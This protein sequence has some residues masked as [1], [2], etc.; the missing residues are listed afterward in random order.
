MAFLGLWACLWKGRLPYHIDTRLYA[1]P[2]HCVNMEAFHRGFIPLWNPYIGCGTPHAANWQSACF[3]PPFWIF[4]FTGLQ[5]WLMWMALGHSALAFWGCY[6]WLRSQKWGSLWSA[7]GALSF[8]GSA[9]MVMCWANL[10]FIAT[11]AWIPWVFWAAHRALGKN[12]TPNWI[13]LCLFLSLQILA[14]YPFFTFYTLIFL[15][16]WFAFQKPSFKTGVSMGLTLLASALL[17]SL[18]WLPFLEFLTY[19]VHDH[20]ND[21]PYFTKPIE[22]LTLLEPGILGKGGAASYGGSFANANFNL[23]FG[24]IPLLVVGVGL[25]RIT[26]VRNK[27]WIFSILFWFLWLAGRHFILWDILPAAWLEWLEP[28]KAVGIFIFCAVTFAAAGLHGFFK[29]R[30]DHPKLNRWAWALSLLWIAD[31]LRVPFQLLH[32]MPNPYQTAGFAR[33]ISRIQSLVG[34]KRML[35]IH[36]PREMGFSGGDAVARSFEMPPRLLLVNSNEVGGIRS[37]DKYLYLGVDGS[38]N[39]TYYMNKGF[40]FGYEGGLLDIAGVGLFLMPQPL[41]GPKYEIAGKEGDDLLIL[42]HQASEDMRFV[43][44]K[45]ILPNRVSVLNAIARS[46]SG[47]GKKVYL[48]EG[49]NGTSVGLSPAAYG[50]LPMIKQVRG[51]EREGAGLASL[52]DEFPTSGFVALNETFAPGWHAW[53]DG[54]PAAILRAYGLFMAVAV[55]ENGFHR[56]EFHYEPFSFRLGLFLSLVTLVWTA[57]YGAKNLGAGYG[58]SLGRVLS[59]ASFNPL[60]TSPGTPRP[61][62]FR[63]KIRGAS[64]R[65]G[66]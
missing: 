53:V 3:Y 51:Y 22:Y 5:D 9:H 52:T 63:K 8:A 4:N 49:T 29:G 31:L 62:K 45:I 10:P 2:D 36:T 39:L 6:L 7:L 42:N 57:A 24:L 30:L 38:E 13:F 55:S 11:A 26:H 32:P 65:K 27:F 56:V 37:A 47:W 12:S 25:L 34:N 23:Y 44:K 48:E 43:G 28:S 46:D 16:V 17:T 40:R 58:S 33:E 60:A 59:S 21:Y 15:L 61:Q 14:G 35:S 64:P 19:S 18:Q 54:K 41:P 20:W 66:S 50:L 1:Y